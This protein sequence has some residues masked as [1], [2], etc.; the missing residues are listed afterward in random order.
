VSPPEVNQPR[1]SPLA[2]RLIRTIRGSGPI[3]VAAYMAAALAD[4]VDGYYTTRDPLGAAGDFITAPEI[5]QMFG[6]IIG[7]WCADLWQQLGEPDPLVLAELGPGRGTLMADVLRALALLPACRAASGVHLVE[8]S[9]TLRAVQAATLA[10]SHPDKPPTWHDRLEDLPPGPLLLIANE[11]FDALPIR[12][13]VRHAGSW[14]EQLVGLDEA[15]GLGFVLGPPCDLLLPHAEEG[16]IFETCEA[17]AAVARTLGA[18]LAA[19][20]GAALIIDYGH[21]VPAPGDTLQAVKAHA[22]APVLADP[23]QA[24]LTAHVDFAALAE[25]ATGAGAVAWGP[26]TQ[27]RFLVANGI[28]HRLARL[29]A[30]CEESTARELALGC[31]RLIDP[32]EMGRLF[33][34]LAV[35]DQ[36]LSRPGGF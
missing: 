8:I 4:P 33:K 5:S 16:A 20:R 36:D 34:V 17:A 29:Q 1:P 2:S 24:D 14:R 15:G 7:L 9:P 28:E 10:A 23:G 18:R 31:R 11:F 30:G 13:W 25:A 26:V 32:Q 12:Q 35:T 21:A 19:E 3:S 6:E 22:Y 27:T